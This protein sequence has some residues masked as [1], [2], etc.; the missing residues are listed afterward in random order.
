MHPV[1]NAPT[2][3]AAILFGVLFATLISGMYVAYE[4]SPVIHGKD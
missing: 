1:F 3:A 2:F 4:N